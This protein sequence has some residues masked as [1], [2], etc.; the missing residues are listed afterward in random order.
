MRDDFIV[1]MT[2]VAPGQHRGWMDRH[3]LDY[4]H[5]RAADGAFLVISA[6]TLAWQAQVGHIGGV[7]AEDDT[8][9][10]FAMAQLEWLKQVLVL[11]HWGVAHFSEC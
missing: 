1:A 11:G 3:W 5:R 4:D 10:E 6:M 8:I 7:C 2:E 9:I